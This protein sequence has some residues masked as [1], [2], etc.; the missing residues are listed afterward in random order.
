MTKIVNCPFKEFKKNTAFGRP[1]AVIPAGTSTNTFS[2]NK[3][4]EKLLK[5]A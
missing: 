2:L 4:E 1:L 3:R 5:Q